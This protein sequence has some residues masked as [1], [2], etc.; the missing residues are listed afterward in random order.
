MAVVDLGNAS[1][2][3]QLRIEGNDDDKFY[4]FDATRVATPLT[5]DT[6]GNVG[7]G[8][9]SPTY[10]LDVRNS[11]AATQIH[12]GGMGGDNG[13]YLLGYSTGT[14]ELIGGAAWD[15]TKWIAK[16]VAASILTVGGGGFNLCGNT[17]LTVGTTFAPA[18]RMFMD[19]SGQLGIGTASPSSLL[20]VAVSAPSALGP[21]LTLTNNGGGENAAAAI[22]FNTHPRSSGGPSINP[23][24][25]IEASGHAGSFSDDL[26]FLVNQPGIPNHGLLD[27]MRITYEGLHVTG[28]VNVTGDVLLTGADCAEQFDVSGPQAPDPGTVVVIDEAGTLRESSDAYDKKVAGVVSGAGDYRH[29]IL[30]DQRLGAEGR[31][32]V[33]LVGKVYCKVDAEYSPVDVGDLLTTSQTPGHAMKAAEPGKAFGAVIGKALGRIE[34]GQGL[35]PILISLQ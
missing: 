14:L 24:S 17:G 15:G 26:V 2:H 9:T 30:M 34:K 25:R 5:V 21:V 13:E 31:V 4:L 8:T 1:R 32:A 27:I 29:G 22:D 35:I 33:A 10:L 12:I 28:V 16:D 6:A 7:I 19:S 23:S 11:T 20:E 3:W 18:Y